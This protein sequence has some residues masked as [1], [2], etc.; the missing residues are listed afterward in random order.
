MYSV[1]RLLTKKNFCMSK[2]KHFLG[3]DVSKEYFDAVILLNNS[4]ANPVHEQFENSKKGMGKL[5]KWLKG[6][7]ATSDNTLICLEHTG[8]YGKLIIKYLLSFGF[9]V[10]VEMSLK[11]IRSI[12]VQRGKND[13]LDA[14][15][16]AYYAMKNADEAVLYKAPSEAV[17]K[18]R[19]LLS[20]R[21]KLTV[22]KATL[23]KTANELKIFDVKLAKLSD[24]SL[25]NTISGIEKD[26]KGI[27]KQIEMLVD[28]N[29]NFDMYSSDS[30]FD[31]D[32]AKLICIDKNME[33]PGIIELEQ[34]Y[35]NKD[36]IPNLAENE[37]YISSTEANKY[38]YWALYMS[39]DNIRDIH[40]LMSSSSKKT[41]SDNRVRCIR[42]F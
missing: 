25:K 2:F 7:Y 27:E 13:K 26:L 21:D 17:D 23:L 28:E 4:K 15:R 20:L 30:Y 40:D 22:T 24:R 32:R 10:W 35:R 41:K 12:G 9:S 42:K 5:Y 6:M 36:F 16:I 33:L 37:W 31:W 34:I 19:K 1:N 39:E 18:I 8:I 11:I 14:E 29:E 38:D 3:I